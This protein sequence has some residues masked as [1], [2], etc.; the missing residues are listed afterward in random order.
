MLAYNATSSW[1]SDKDM[2]FYL[3]KTTLGNID[4]MEYQSEGSGST[5]I[6]KDNA[7][8]GLNFML[9]MD[10]IITMFLIFFWIYQIFI[11]K[12]ELKSKHSPRSIKNYAV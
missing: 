1:F 4:G 10:I 5:S 12:I 3:E 7:Q 11:S 9:A 6:G 2:K 8:I